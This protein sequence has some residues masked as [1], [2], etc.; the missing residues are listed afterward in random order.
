VFGGLNFALYVLMRRC[1]TASNGSEISYPQYA[2][3]YYGDF[4]DY[5]RQ[6]LGDDRLIMSRPVDG[7]PPVSLRCHRTF[8]FQLHECR[9]HGDDHFVGVPVILPAACG[10]LRLGG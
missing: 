6:K 10:L 7:D 5:T 9:R 2:D 4:Y 8:R 1:R 3:L